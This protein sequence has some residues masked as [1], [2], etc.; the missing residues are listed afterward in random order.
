MVQIREAQ[1]PYTKWGLWRDQLLEIDRQCL[2]G[3]AWD[4]DQW[5]RFSLH[6]VKTLL[7][8]KE[9]QLVGFL[10]WQPLG[11][12]EAEI[13]KLGVRPTERRCGVAKALLGR[14]E[15]QRDKGSRFFLEVRASNSGAKGLYE[16]LGYTQ[17]GTRT[18]YYRHPI[19]D[20][21]LL[22]KQT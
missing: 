7:A 11:N 15:Q 5:Q 4:L 3:E 14:L 8:W 13:T 21:F 20:A 10:V 19:E 16:S 22:E 6:S 18:S 1:G 17:T 12:E 2:P 9:D